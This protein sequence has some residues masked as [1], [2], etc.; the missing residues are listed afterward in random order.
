VVKVLI[1]QTEIDSFNRTMEHDID[2]CQARSRDGRG[3]G[4]SDYEQLTET[5][6][7]AGVPEG[8]FEHW[9]AVIDGLHAPL[10]GN[11]KEHFPL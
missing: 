1:T 10:C 8:R 3:I 7:E 2:V 5:L 11:R 9:E 6:A 4:C